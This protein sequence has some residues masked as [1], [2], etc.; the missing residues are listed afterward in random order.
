MKLCR[1]IRPWSGIFHSCFLILSFLKKFSR[2]SERWACGSYAVLFRWRF[3]AAEACR[4]E[5]IRFCCA[6]FFNRASAR[7][8]RM[9]SLNGRPGLSKRWKTWVEHSAHKNSRPPGIGPFHYEAV[10]GQL[11]RICR[12]QA[13]E[14][15]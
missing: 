13:G 6:L 12:R 4:R 3:F 11:G 5:N 2:P 7:Y 9:K 1:A 15:L 8:A 10:L 14:A